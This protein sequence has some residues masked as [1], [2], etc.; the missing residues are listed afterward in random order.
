MQ[1]IKIHI[2]FKFQDGPWGGGNQFLKAL[3][4][5]F[6]KMGIYEDDVSNAN[7]ILFNSHQ[8]ASKLISI[9]KKYPNKI[10]IH[11]IDGPVTSIRGNDKSTDKF[12]Y[13]LNSYIADGTIFQSNWSR[14]QNYIQGI[15]KT[16]YNV[17]IL[18]APNFNIF[19]NINKKSF[20][21]NEKIK[22]IV[23]SWSSNMRKGFEIY[24]YLDKNLDFS[25]YEMTFIGNSP[26]KFENIKMIAPLSSE[27]ISE[28]LKK[29]DIYITASKA[30][31]C[32]NSLIEAL[33]CGLP[34]VVFNDGGHPEIVGNGG[35]TFQGKTDILKKIDKVAKNYELYQSEINLPVLSDVAINYANFCIKVYKKIGSKNNNKIKFKD[36][37]YLK[38]LFFLWR[39]KRRIVFFTK[40]KNIVKN[41]INIT[42][43]R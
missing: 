7:I 12:S 13:L 43:L 20:K 21:E 10:Y 5:E 4:K 11:R 23:T 24:A 37:I 30:D 31:P 32:S 33:H 35:E 8:H 17:T 41:R 36:F 18:N 39:L 38:T 2:L 3:K 6:I 28:Y 15:K 42:N 27:K 1:K 25:R 14:K 34:S 22:I 16:D 40:I 19:N 9:K 29:S 26:I